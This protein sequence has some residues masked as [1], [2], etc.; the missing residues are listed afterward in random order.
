MCDLIGERARIDAILSHAVNHGRVRNSSNARELLDA[1]LAALQAQ[2][3]DACPD[4]CIRKRCEE[5]TT[6]VARSRA[7]RMREAASR[8]GGASD[9]ESSDACLE[10]L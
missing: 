6:H 10:V 1:A 2:Y 8:S 5:F 7:R 3:D 4:A 9:N